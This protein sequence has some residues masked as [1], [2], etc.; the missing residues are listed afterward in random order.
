MNNALV[1]FRERF[2]QLLSERYPSLDRFYLEHDFSKG[3]LSHILRGRRNPSTLTL[4]RLA[5]MLG[6]ELVDFFVFPQKDKRHQIMA[7]LAECSEEALDVV[8]QKL[9]EDIRV[10]SKRIE[11]SAGRYH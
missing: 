3:H 5:G 9:L 10:Q 11:R 2:G 4:Y 8:L 7:L 6:V 1:L